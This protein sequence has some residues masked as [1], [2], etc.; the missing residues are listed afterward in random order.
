MFAGCRKPLAKSGILLRL[1][2]SQALLPVALDIPF[3][4]RR[5]GRAGDAAAKPD[6]AL[7]RHLARRYFSD[8]LAVK[9]WD[10]A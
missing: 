9:P 4:R 10:V 3:P 6:R 7:C 1:A 8:A 2:L 5:H